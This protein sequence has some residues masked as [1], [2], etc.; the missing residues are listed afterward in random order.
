MII[1]FLKEVFEK[2]NEKKSAGAKLPSM[3]RVKAAHKI[4]KSRLQISCVTC[5]SK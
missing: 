3:Q 2:K 4:G 5:K 1:V